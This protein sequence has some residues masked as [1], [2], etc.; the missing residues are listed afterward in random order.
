MCAD[1]MHIQRPAG[2]L[3]ALLLCRRL[4]QAE[5]EAGINRWLAWLPRCC[6]AASVLYL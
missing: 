4:R 1:M 5:V 2:A 6:C 3:H